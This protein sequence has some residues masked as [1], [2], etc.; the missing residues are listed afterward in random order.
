MRNQIRITVAIFFH[1][2][3]GSFNFW[4]KATK[5]IQKHWQKK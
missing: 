3:H 5:S 2:G 1:D 4:A